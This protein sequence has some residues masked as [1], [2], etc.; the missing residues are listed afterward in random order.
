MNR[1]LLC[2]LTVFMSISV[3]AQIRTPVTWSYGVKKINAK[4]AIV[5]FKAT[6]EKDWHIYSSTQKEGGPQ[7]TSFSFEKSADYSLVGKIAEPK[8]L[9]EYNDL[10]KLDVLY[11]KNTVV[12]QQKIKLVKKTIL[13]TTVNFMAC[14]EKECTPATEVKF[15]IP[16]G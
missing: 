5:L 15:N 9:V 6:M 7:K 1:T 4:E 10:I 14:T 2:L 3:S 13:K 12:F 16:V 8:P 11:F